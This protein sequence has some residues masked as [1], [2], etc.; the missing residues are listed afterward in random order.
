MSMSFRALSCACLL[1]LLFSPLC[2]AQGFTDIRAE[3]LYNDNLSRS[4]HA[5]DMR[6]DTSISF[7]AV[8]GYHLQPGDYTGLTIT[9]TLGR[10]QYR[11]HTG[12]SNTEANLGLQLARKFGLGDRAPSLTLELETGR[13]EFN[14]GIRDAWNYRAGL[15]LHKRLS[16]RVNLN[17]GLRYEKRDGDHDLPRPL[18][19]RPRPGNS[20]DVSTRSLFVGGEYEL[21]ANYW[22]SGNYAFQDGEVTSTALSYPRIFEAATAITLDP[23][24]G[25]LTVAYRLPARTHIVTLELNRAVLQAGTL[26]AGFEYQITQGSKSIDYD[27]ALLRC[28]FLYSF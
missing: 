1:T 6:E 2:V 7:A 11:R 22:L 8:A 9:G 3:V 20:W 28:G 23:Q 24:F 26:Y 16:D 25:P 10:T 4:E 19:V 13:N 5:S 17:G 27:V 21:D 12:L 18:P 14:L 15:S